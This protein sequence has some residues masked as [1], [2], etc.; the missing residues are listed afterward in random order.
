MRDNLESPSLDHL[1]EQVH[2]VP[3]ESQDLLV[4]QEYSTKY[5]V[6]V[7][8]LVLQACTGSKDFKEKQDRRVCHLF[9]IRK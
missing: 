5:N 7:V 2:L 8:L 6:I 9:H 1:G 4:P 3:K